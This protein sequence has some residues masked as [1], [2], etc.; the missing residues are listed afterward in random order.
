M[1]KTIAY[2]KRV[3]L[4]RD[5]F[6]RNIIATCRLLANIDAEDSRKVRLAK[7]AVARLDNANDAL[8]LSFIRIYI[9]YLTGWKFPEGDY[10]D[11]DFLLENIF[12]KFGYER[13]DL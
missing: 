8:Q 3:A 4:T 11:E 9:S 2:G 5:L 6:R 12:Y 7:L 1:V 10:S 13:I